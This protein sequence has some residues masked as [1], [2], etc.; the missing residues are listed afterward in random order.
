[1]TTVDENH[2]IYTDQTGKLPIMSSQGNKN[3]LIMHVYDD[4][5][6]LT[7]PLK[8]R[9]SSHIMGAYTKQVEYLTHIGYRPRVHW[10]DNKAAASLKKYNKQNYID[11][12][13][14]LPHIHR[15]NS[16]DRAIRK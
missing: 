3:I 5:A 1:M 2:K 14:M 4:N 7:S 6:I 13:L 15:V 10:L 8:S 9:S 11:Y 16:A 12:N